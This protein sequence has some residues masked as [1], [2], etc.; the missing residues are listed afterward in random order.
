MPSL[1]A[2]SCLWFAHSWFALTIIL[3]M[4]TLVLGYKDFGEGNFA[5]AVWL[6]IQALV[7]A[8]RLTITGHIDWFIYIPYII[9]AAVLAGILNN[10]VKHGF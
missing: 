4:G 10:R 8:L 6:G 7:I 9:G 1:L 5:R 2:S 3:S